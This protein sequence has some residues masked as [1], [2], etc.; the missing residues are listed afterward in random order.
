MVDFNILYNGESLKKELKVKLCAPQINHLRGKNI[1]HCGNIFSSLA[2]SITM[3][4]NSTFEY[5]CQLS[6]QV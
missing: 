1:D 2:C 4:A 3:I 5:L 6:C